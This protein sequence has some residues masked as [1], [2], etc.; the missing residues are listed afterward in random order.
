MCDHCMPKCDLYKTLV[1]GDC[2]AK[3]NMACEGV[4][5]CNRMPLTARPV[6]EK[7]PTAKEQGKILATL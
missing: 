2:T 3:Q 4:C 5:V 7:W 1:C 6:L